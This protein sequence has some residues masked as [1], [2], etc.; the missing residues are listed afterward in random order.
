MGKW[1]EQLN[2]RQILSI[3]YGVCIMSLVLTATGAWFVRDNNVS[4]SELLTLRWIW[5][6][7]LV[8]FISAILLIGRPLINRMASQNERMRAKHEELEHVLQESKQ[9]ETK[10]Q[11]R[12]ELIEVLASKESL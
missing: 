7:G 4:P 3:L 5:M 12:N 6:I 11:Y 9:N 1:I 10:L 8:M 2:S